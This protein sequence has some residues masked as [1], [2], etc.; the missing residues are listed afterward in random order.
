M[1]KYTRLA[2]YHKTQQEHVI[3]LNSTLQ[4][5]LYSV[6]YPTQLQG[7]NEQHLAEGI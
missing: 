5:T 1:R 4:E 2:A 3:Q 7:M 6:A